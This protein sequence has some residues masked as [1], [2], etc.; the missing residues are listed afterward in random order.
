MSVAQWVEAALPFLFKLVEEVFT[1]RVDQEK[2]MLLLADRLKLRAQ[3]Q[4]RLD[5]R[6]GV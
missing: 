5:K 1:S 2:A 6:K 3:A 4:A